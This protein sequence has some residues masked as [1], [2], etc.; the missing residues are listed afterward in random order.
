MTGFVVFVEKKKKS[1]YIYICVCVCV[2]AQKNKSDNTDRNNFFA[3]FFFIVLNKFQPSPKQFFQKSYFRKFSNS[4]FKRTNSFQK[5]TTQT[6][7]LIL[8]IV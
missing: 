4:F 7:M 1:I 2:H 8:H 5:E 3:L 6:K